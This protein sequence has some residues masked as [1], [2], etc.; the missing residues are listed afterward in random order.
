MPVFFAH[1]GIF[2]DFRMLVAPSKEPRAWTLPRHRNGFGFGCQAVRRCGKDASFASPQ[3]PATTALQLPVLRSALEELVAL[4][5][6]APWI[7]LEVHI[8]RLG[9]R[10]D[11]VLA[12][13]SCVI[14]IELKVGAKKFERLDYDQAWDFRIDLKNFHAPSHAA[15]RAVR[16][17]PCGVSLWEGPPPS[18]RF[19]DDTLRP[20]NASFVLLTR[21]RQETVIFVPPGAKRDK[22]RSPGFF[23]GVSQYRTDLG[24]PQV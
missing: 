21:A 17:G 15:R 9:R 16:R 23:E 4:P 3:P 20:T 14:P 18:H 6:A 22:T 7:H 13:P 24:V 10:V 1:S 11:A 5:P 19:R 2:Q 8:P 12:T